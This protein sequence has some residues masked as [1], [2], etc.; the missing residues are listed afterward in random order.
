MKKIIFLSLFL[1]AA[2]GQSQT[3]N[4]VKLMGDIQTLSSEKY[5]GRKTGTPGNKLAADYIIKRL[6]DIGLSSYEKNYTHPFTFKTRQNEERQGN[7]LIGFVKGKSD[8]VIV[9]SAH[10]DH[11][12]VNGNDIYYGA[13][14]NA[15]G[16]GALLAFAEYFQKNE[17]QHTLLFIAFDAEESGLRGA[18]AFVKEPA[19]SKD[20][21][22]LNINMDMIA[23]NDK[24]E[25]YASGTYKN[26]YLKS[27]IEGEDKNTGI[28]ILFGH[29]LPN[30]GSE[31]WTM[32]SDQGPFAKENI[33]FIYFGVEDHKDYHKPTDTFANINQDFYYGASTAILKSIIKVD[34]KLN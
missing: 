3:I 20:K 10:Y 32:Q 13:D 19:V 30:T 33:P 16:V 11:V 2:A 31:D 15:S 9:I 24:G 1:T 22:I 23:H 28:K 29:D 18:S 6:N 21:I 4:R 14:D 27:I 26:P 5:E 12:G 7:N 25:L 8:K 17:P 34:K